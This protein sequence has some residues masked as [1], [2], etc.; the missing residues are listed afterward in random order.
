MNDQIIDEIPDIFDKS[1]NQ[2]NLT[3]NDLEGIDC[4]PKN[5]KFNL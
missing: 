3:L 4:S 2:E 5:F 1:E